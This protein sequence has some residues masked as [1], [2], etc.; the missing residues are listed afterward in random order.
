MSPQVLP[1]NFSRAQEEA[2]Y[3]DGLKQRGLDTL[4][5]HASALRWQIAFIAGVVCVL[6]WPFVPSLVMLSWFAALVSVREI[7]ARYL[8]KLAANRALP[9]GQRLRQVVVWNSALGTTHGAAALFMY[10][11]SPQYDALLTMILVSWAAGAVST[12]GPLVRAY[13]SY[14]SWVFLPT[15]LMWLIEGNLVGYGVAV[16]IVMFFG[17]QYRYATQNAALF[18]E[19]FRIRRE[20]EELVQ[21]LAQEQ[22]A[23]ARARDAAESANQAKTRFLAA[24]SHDLRQPLHALTLHSGLLARDPHAEN[25][26]RIAQE[27]STS[28]DSLAD[29]LDSLLDISK[30]DAG[31]VSADHRPILLHRL[32]AN[33][34]SAHQTQAENKGLKL[35]ARCPDDAVVETDPLLLERVLRNLLDNAIKYTDQGSVSIDV[36]ESGAELLVSVSDTGRG[37][38]EDAKKKVFEEFYQAENQGRDKRKGLGLGLAIVRR[39]AEVLGIEVELHSELGRGTTLTLRM[40]RGSQPAEER[41]AEPR[42][43]DAL[44]GVKVLFVDDEQPVRLA[45]RHVLERFGCQADEAA[46]TNEALELATRNPPHIVLADYQLG[47]GD[48]G[49][50]LITKLRDRF[51]GLPALLISGDTDPRRLAEAEKAGLYLM[52]KPVSLERLQVAMEAVLEAEARR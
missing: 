31:V 23:L 14:A 41:R 6:V 32:I 28:I 43:G 13:V 42:E 5:A 30:L 16:M 40:P 15:A 2:N 49:L 10:W 38:P 51:P 48:C 12:G 9:I 52:H 39:V 50:Q 7:R 44:R 11:L 4:S 26:G 19:S 3:A 27:I 36:A 22:A 37:I 35:S 46:S 1:P 20:N 18:E 25:A 47:E 34:V 24:A 45:M 8:V 21:R 17:V 33:L 29:L